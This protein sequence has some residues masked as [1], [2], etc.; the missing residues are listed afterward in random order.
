M[1]EDGIVF[2]T[3]IRSRLFTQC[4]KLMH[5]HM[6]NRHRTRGDSTKIH[7]EMFLSIVFTPLGS[8]EKLLDI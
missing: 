4:E 8:T 3:N 2:A 7:T 1:Q 5:L 6:A